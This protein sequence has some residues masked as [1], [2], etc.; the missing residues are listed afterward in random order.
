M[1]YLPIFL[2]LKGKPCLVVGGGEVALRKASLLL[3]AG[4]A[5]TVVAPELHA[6]FAAHPEIKHVA[7]RFL[8]SHLDGAA[9]VIAATNETQTNNDISR[10]AKARNIPVNVV[11]NPGLC[12]F[13]MPAILDRSPIVVAFSSGGASPVLTRMLR[14]KLETLIPQG[15]GKLAA[16]SAKFRD[17]IKA[18]IHEPAKRRIFWED[19]LE[20][21]VAEKVFAGDE[22]SAETHLLA[23]LKEQKPGATGEVYLVGAG[24]GDPDLLTFRALRLMQKADV[25][26]YDNLVSKPVLEM[27]RRDAERIF[28]GKKRG[29]HTMPQEGINDLLVRLAKTGKRVLR[30]KGGDPFIFGRGGE[31]IE[32]LAEHKISFQ[33]VPGI[34]AASGV[35]SYAGIPLTHRDH[36]QSCVF[37]TGHLKDDSMDLD[38]EML[39]R[40]RQTIVVYMGLHGLDILCSQLI[41]HGLAASTPAA[42]VQQGTTQN[43]RVVCGTLST[44]PGIVETANLQAPT[45]IIIGGVVSLREKLSWFKPGGTVTA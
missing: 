18:Q 42:I 12:T 44:L 8:A 28:V 4:A 14:G 20:G 11:D 21:P 34:T 13:I 19:V 6:S 7:E 5:V 22:T 1:D 25:V 43:Q 36:A 17:A 32:K 16:F 40:P 38:W 29:N 30:L 10:E 39:A 35:S 15:Y 9:L 27:T 37:V 31:E 2:N 23:M 45:L 33:V 26:L 3:Q 24:P 41:A